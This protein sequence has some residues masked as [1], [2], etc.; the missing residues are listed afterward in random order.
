MYYHN[1][2][3]SGTYVRSFR[4]VEGLEV[5]NLEPT[6]EGKY[7]SRPQ[8]NYEFKSQKVVFF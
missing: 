5:M 3:M 6:Q 1:C 7:G 2:L 4:V 8:R